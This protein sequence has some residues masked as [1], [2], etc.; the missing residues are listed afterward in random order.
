M[1]SFLHA[2]PGVLLVITSV[3]LALSAGPLGTYFGKTN[4]GEDD[5]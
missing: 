3:A 2:A 4:D 5:Q 1:H